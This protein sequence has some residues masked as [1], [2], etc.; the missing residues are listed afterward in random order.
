MVEDLPMRAGA[1]RYAQSIWSRESQSK[2][3]AQKEWKEK[4]SE[5]F[6]LRNELVHHF[7]FAFRKDPDLVRKAQTIREGGSNADMLQDLSDL[8]VLGKENQELLKAIGFDV[9]LLD[10]AALWANDLAVVLANANGEAGDDVDVKDIRDKAYTHMK[11]AVDEIR[12]TGQYVFWRD[13]DRKKGYVSA[14]QK[15]LNQRRKENDPVQI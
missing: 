10:K 8:S 6:G 11:Q 5:A 3:E 9:K 7:S 12:T 13:E 14:Y 15:R 4:S 1:C 2:E